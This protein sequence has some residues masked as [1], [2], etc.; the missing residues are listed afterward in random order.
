MTITPDELK[1]IIREVLVEETNSNNKPDQ[2]NNRFYTRDEACELLHISKS[3]L[4]NYVQRKFINCSRV[5][6]R[7]L[8]T[9]KDINDALAKN[10]N[11]N[12]YE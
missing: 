9:Q 5:G 12:S 8:L 6:H 11:F 1:Q 4:D 2:N 3:T 7:V 10:R